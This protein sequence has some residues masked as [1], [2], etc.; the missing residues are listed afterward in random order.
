MSN[1][2]FFDSIEKLVSYLGSV[3]YKIDYE[4][5][6]SHNYSS[7][8]AK[9]IHIDPLTIENLILLAKIIPTFNQYIRDIT[10]GRSIDERYSNFKE[11]LDSV[12]KDIK[13]KIKNKTSRIHKT[14]NFILRRKEKEINE[15]ATQIKS[16]IEGFKEE[17][18][19][20][21]EEIEKEEKLVEAYK[22]LIDV[23]MQSNLVVDQLLEKIN[24]NIGEVE[25]WREENRTALIN[26]SDSKLMLNLER[27]KIELDTLYE[28]EVEARETIR[29]LKYS[30]N[31]QLILSSSLFETL[32]VS[33]KNRTKLHRNML[34]FMALDEGAITSLIESIVMEERTNIN[35]LF[36]DIVEQ[37]ET[38]IAENIKADIES[39]KAQEEELNAQ[40]IR[41]E[42]KER[43][44]EEERKK[45]Q[46]EQRQVAAAIGRLKIEAEKEN[47]KR[48]ERK[49]EIL[50]EFE[51][52]RAR[53]ARDVNSLF[54]SNKGN[55]KETLNKTNTEYLFYNEKKYSNLENIIHKIH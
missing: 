13:L 36:N 15:I 11:D 50:R 6:E 26:C 16:F 29:D 53:I 31:A 34:Y 27:D 4:R 33:H 54:V 55:L 23:I 32:Q 9:I 28:F 18:R 5:N 40:A 43:T 10:V 20:I 19:F 30:F 44:L 41:Q 37:V 17:L 24:S 25:K 22:L 12:N 1:Q 47:E 46:E 8:L 45:F 51:L 52:R 39:K 7:L 3:G 21:N 49:E 35:S 38:Q 2:E 14:W 42:E 48:P